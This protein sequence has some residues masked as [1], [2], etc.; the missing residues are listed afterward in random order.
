MIPAVSQSL[1]SLWVFIV[2]LKLGPV[3][4]VDP[5]LE[6]DRV[7]EKT[8]KEKTRCDPARPG[9]KPGCN[10]LTFFFFY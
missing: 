6:L 3:R 10:P 5:G 4:W 1:L 2:V 8:E 7:E 9:Q